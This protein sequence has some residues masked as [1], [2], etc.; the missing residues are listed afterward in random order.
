M[1]MLILCDYKQ[2]RLPTGV[3]RY[4]TDNLYNLNRV[5]PSCTVR[6]WSNLHARL[7]T[8][9]YRNSLSPD[10]SLPGLALEGRV[11]P[12]DPAGETRRCSLRVFLRGSRA[13]PPP[14]LSHNGQSQTVLSFPFSQHLGRRHE[15]RQVLC[16]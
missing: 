3:P 15:P 7:R 10:L 5:T 13:P 6:R 16:K 12:S 2:K 11:L 14:I 8:L 4:Q 9:T 1:R